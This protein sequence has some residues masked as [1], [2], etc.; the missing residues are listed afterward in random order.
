MRPPRTSRRVVRKARPANIKRKPGPQVTTVLLFLT[1]SSLT[2]VLSRNLIQM[3]M[4]PA[5]KD[6][7]WDTSFILSEASLTGRIFA[8]LT[9][10]QSSPALLTVLIYIA[11]WAIT[12]YFYWRP[13][14]M[15]QEVKHARTT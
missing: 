13:P 10:Y 15:T 9:G 11:Y 12:A 3:G 2:L 6:N 5:L 14:T 7:V 8:G 4:L 1:A